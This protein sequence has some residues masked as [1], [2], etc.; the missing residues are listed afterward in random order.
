LLV[1]VVWAASAI[2]VRAAAAVCVSKGKG[3]SKGIKWVFWLPLLS[4]GSLA[5]SG[6]LV[7]VGW[8]ERTD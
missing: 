7:G 3:K 8:V 6:L 2:G 5:T 4:L 1:V